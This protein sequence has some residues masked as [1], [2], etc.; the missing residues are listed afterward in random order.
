M[1]IVVTIAMLMGLCV[2]LLNPISIFHKPPADYFKTKLFIGIFLLAAGLWNAFWHG[3]Q[4]LDVF[5]GKAGLASGLIMIASALIIL[6]SLRRA[7][8][9]VERQWFHWLIIVGL[10]LSFL[11][12]AITIVQIYAGMDIIR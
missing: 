6:L 9:A 8:E 7:K 3:L 12:Y 5:W 11:L 10:L 4:N 1:G 2:L